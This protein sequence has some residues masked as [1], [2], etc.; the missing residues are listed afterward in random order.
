M[1]VDSW[2]SITPGAFGPW[3]LASMHI[4][5]HGLDEMPAVLLGEDAADGRSAVSG[6][7]LNEMT[8]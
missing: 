5:D 7:N 3:P 8:R 2:A 1:L 6:S 4:D